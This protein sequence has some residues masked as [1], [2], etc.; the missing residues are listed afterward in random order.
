MKYPASCAGCLLLAAARAGVK[1][2]D[3]IVSAG[4]QVVTERHMLLNVRRQFRI[5]D[6][7][8]MKLWRDGEYLEVVLH[9]DEAFEE[10]PTE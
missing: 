1:G 8:P 4:G 5:G 7:L 6:N 9:L 10:L 3:V 2:G